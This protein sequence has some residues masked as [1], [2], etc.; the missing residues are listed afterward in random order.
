M[1]FSHCL[2]GYSSYKPI[3]PPFDPSIPDQAPFISSHISYPSIRPPSFQIILNP[4]LIWEHFRSILNAKEE[5]EECAL[6]LN[7]KRMI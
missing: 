3:F 5:A 4:G 7:R 1:N 2:E 6:D